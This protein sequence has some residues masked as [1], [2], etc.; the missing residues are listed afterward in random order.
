MIGF[1]FGAIAGGMA[2]YYWRD[3]IHDYMN[4]RAP[5]MREKAASRLGNIG[6]RAGSA[7]DRARSRI[8]TTVRAGQDKIRTKGTGTTG[9]T[10]TTT[11]GTS[12][13]T[14][15]P[16]GGTEAERGGWAPGERR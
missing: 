1:V 11:A 16:V 8:D 13:G 5:E 9:T 14:Y 10:G 12:T 3:R 7:L 2:A 4:T 15:P 6:E